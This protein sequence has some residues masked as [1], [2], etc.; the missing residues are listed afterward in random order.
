MMQI[1][2]AR[3]I[4]KVSHDATKKHI[5]K[6]YL[7]RAFDSHPDKGGSDEAFQKVQ[8]AYELLCQV[9]KF[10]NQD[11]S[12]Q[13]H[14]EPGPARPPPARPPPARPPPAHPQHPPHMFE[15]SEEDIQKRKKKLEKIQE[16]A[17]QMNDKYEE[18]YGP[19]DKPLDTGYGPVR[20]K[21]GRMRGPKRGPSHNVLCGCGKK[22]I[23]SDRPGSHR[24]KCK[25]LDRT[26]IYLIATG[27]ISNDARK[28]VHETRGDMSLLEIESAVPTLLPR[29][30]TKP[31]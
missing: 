30:P 9:Y 22:W 5:R 8:E 3:E 15:S 13:A 16:E 14:P 26:I 19:L 27:T 24:V 10:Q 11:R 12:D 4:L 25:L 17:S 21:H 20:T 6:A 31:I 7:E 23:W 18:I 2:E 1:D 29:P 28:I